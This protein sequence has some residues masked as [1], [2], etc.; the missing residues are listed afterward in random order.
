MNLSIMVTLT[1]FFDWRHGNAHRPLARDLPAPCLPAACL[2]DM[3][4]GGLVDQRTGV[5][6]ADTA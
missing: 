1:L 6:V 4:F 5:A 3:E 2:P